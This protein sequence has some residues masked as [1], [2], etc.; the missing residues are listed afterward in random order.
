MH[1]KGPN[2][3]VRLESLLHQEIATAVQQ[4]RDPRL[5]FVTIT[6]VELT[7]DLHQ[8]TAYWTVLGDDTQRRLTTHAL[9]AARAHVQ[10]AYAPAVKT[11]LL[12]QLRFVPDDAE[13]TRHDIDA[14]I[15]RARASDPDHGE[16]PEPPA[17][18]LPQA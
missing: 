10:Q 5:G 12:P 17:P 16:R 6:R 7:G 3:K 13:R 9:D 2:R 1:A 11:R 14:L 18:A 15:R 8:C 4:L